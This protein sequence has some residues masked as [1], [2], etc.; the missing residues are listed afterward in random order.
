V[1]SK[2]EN[3]SQS[4]DFELQRRRCNFLQR[5]GQPSAFLNKKSVFYFEKRSNLGTTALALY[6]AVNL[7]VVGGTAADFYFMHNCI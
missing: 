2:L 1:R 3:W 7:K 5:H 4:C 6:V